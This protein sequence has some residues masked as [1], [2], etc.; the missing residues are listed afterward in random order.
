M[1][2]ERAE[3]EA[4][5]FAA[6]EIAMEASREA[7][8]EATG[9]FDLVARGR[10]PSTAATATPRDASPRATTPRAASP[11]PPPSASVVQIDLSSSAP[12]AED[13]DR[14]G[15]DRPHDCYDG[16]RSE[17]IN[18][19]VLS[20]GAVLAGRQTARAHAGDGRANDGAWRAERAEAMVREAEELQA[21]EL[22]AR[23]MQARAEAAVREVEEIKA[24]E[25]QARAEQIKARELQAR[26]EAAT[27]EVEEIKAREMHARERHARQ[28][29]EAEARAEGAQAYQ[30]GLRL[31][32]LEAEM[33]ARQVSSQEV[34]S[35]EM[36]SREFHSRVAPADETAARM[37]A[38]QLEVALQGEA[39][40]R[41][42]DERTA[43]AQRT[44]AMRREADERAEALRCSMAEITSRELHSR[45]A[46]RH[47]LEASEA[48]LQSRE[49]ALHEQL[50][51]QAS[52][53]A[54]GLFP[55]LTLPWP[56]PSPHPPLASSLPLNLP[57]PSPSPPSL[58]PPPLLTVPRPTLLAGR[59]LCTRARCAAIGTATHR[60]TRTRALPPCPRIYSYLSL[61]SHSQARASE[62]VGEPQELLNLAP[63]IDVSA[64]SCALS[65]TADLA[66]PSHSQA[67]SRSCCGRKPTRRRPPRRRPP[68]RA[69]R[70]APRTTRLWRGSPNSRRS[71]PL[72]S[73]TSS[74][75]T[76]WPP[77]PHSCAID[78]NPRRR[79]KCNA[80]RQRRREL[81]RPAAPRAS[82]C[83]P[84][85]TGHPPRLPRPE[86]CACS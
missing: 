79:T 68:R 5:A 29:R 39:L 57:R 13:H 61:P 59:G 50:L 12:W 56:L 64:S 37:A 28:V 53:P 84:Q 55:P 77:P 25:M 17:D 44:E 75:H 16:G 52:P 14:K 85:R 54:L 15:H 8:M 1:A 9:D 58:G 33:H 4:A 49:A 63:S 24:R 20:L 11:R 6:E 22:Q 34:H 65:F 7:S 10:G 82:S 67:S 72:S 27:R 71:S 60:G 76:A 42:A 66:L 74:R 81:Q 45:E 62:R 31:R 83:T 38:L 47:S 3:A 46:M 21:R 26:A 35:R 30:M 51:E 19:E 70:R 18:P 2:A 23:E 69:A 78:V 86:S 73:P 36:P 32:A 40:Q 48:R 41:E 43:A 80:W